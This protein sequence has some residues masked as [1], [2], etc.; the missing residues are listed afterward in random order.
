[1][2]EIRNLRSSYNFYKS[3][4]IEL[5]N[6]IKPISIKVYLE[7]VLG[8]MKFIMKKVFDGYDV[9]LSAGDSLGTIGVRGRKFTPVITE[10]GQVKGVP[11]SW[12]ETKKLWDS[13][14][15]AKAKKQLV[16]CFNEHSN[17][18]VYHLVWLKYNM[19]LHNKVYYSLTF[20]R[21]NKRT[22]RQAILDGKEF[23]VVD[24]TKKQSA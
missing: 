2:I 10:D 20:S 11:P 9:E 18:V 19:R 14:P 23:L 6:T 13:N 1:M 22:L 7:I 17:G 21:K 16:Y 5:D 12:S 3:T 24:N 15:E 8:F 4:E